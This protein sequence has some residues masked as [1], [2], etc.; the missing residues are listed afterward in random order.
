MP[1]L[2]LTYPRSHL[3]SLPAGERRDKATGRG[4]ESHLLENQPKIVDVPEGSGRVYFLGHHAAARA[5]D[6]DNEAEVVF[7][8]PPPKRTFT[9]RVRYRY[10]GR[11]TPQPYPL[12]DNA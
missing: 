3:I 11:G 7:Q 1:T 9:M 10:T 12:D 8:S 4:R 6:S 5:S 2:A